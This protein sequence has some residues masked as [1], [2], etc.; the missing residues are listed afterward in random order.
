M[1]TG[2]V[3][4]FAFDD[5]FFHQAAAG[6]KGRD[7]TLQQRWSNWEQQAV[8]AAGSSP[9]FFFPPRPKRRKPLGGVGSTWCDAAASGSGSRMPDP[10]E[11][12]RA[13]IRVA[14]SVEVRYSM[15]VSV[16]STAALLASCSSID[17]LD[18]VVFLSQPSLVRTLCDRLGFATARRLRKG[19]LL[20]SSTKDSSSIRSAASQASFGSRTLLSAFRL[21]LAVRDA[22]TATRREEGR[23]RP[24]R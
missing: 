22:L 18:R 2:S 11:L 8:S 10:R 14:N 5:L 20:I 13:G 9:F 4:F 17:C 24:T 15:D 19:I 21:G 7:R 23:C 16:L 3:E 12:D 6:G 1:M